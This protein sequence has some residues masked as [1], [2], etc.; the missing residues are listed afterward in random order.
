MDIVDIIKE[1]QDLLSENTEWKIVIKVI[2][3]I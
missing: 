3:R 2:P 1:A